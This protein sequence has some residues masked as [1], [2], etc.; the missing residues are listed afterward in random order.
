MN[1]LAI[2]LRS[3]AAVA[4]EWALRVEMNQDWPGQVEDA[5]AGIASSLRAAQ[6]A[7]ARRRP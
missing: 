3:I 2:Y 4:N 7:A 6:S 5:L 1:E